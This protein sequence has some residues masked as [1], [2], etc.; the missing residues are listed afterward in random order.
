MQ[1]LNAQ[2]NN[3]LRKLLPLYHKGQSS[4]GYSVMSSLIAMNK[5]PTAAELY[6]LPL[7]EA[8]RDISRMYTSVDFPYLSLSEEKQWRSIIKAMDN[9]ILFVNNQRRTLQLRHARHAPQN[10]IS[11]WQYRDAPWYFDLS[12]LT[13]NQVTHI[14]YARDEELLDTV[15]WVSAFNSTRYITTYRVPQVGTIK[16]VSTSFQ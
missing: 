8:L 10:T 9:T 1:A 12:N 6:R 16:V 13:D 7:L 15:N 4:A 11:I 14:V 3:K 2:L 5:R